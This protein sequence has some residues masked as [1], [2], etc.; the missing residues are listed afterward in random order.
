MAGNLKRIGNAVGGMFATAA[1]AV[2]GAIGTVVVPL[3][4][5][6]LYTAAALIVVGAFAPGAPAALLHAG[7]QLLGFGVDSSLTLANAA[8]PA[9]LQGSKWVAAG[10]LTSGWHGITC[11]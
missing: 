5:F 3:A 11:G 2:C 4:K 1:E 9:M 6:A 7:G 8:G 10:G